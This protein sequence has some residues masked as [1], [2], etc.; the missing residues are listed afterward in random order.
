MGNRCNN[1]YCRRN[2]H[3]GVLSF[4]SGIKACRDSGRHK[5]AL[6]KA[7]K[8][9][10]YGLPAAL[11]TGIVN[12]GDYI[13][14]AITQDG[15]NYIDDETLKTIYEEADRI[16]LFNESLDFQIEAVDL[17]PYVGQRVGTLPHMNASD[18]LLAVM[19]SHGGATLAQQQAA[20]QIP[21]GIYMYISYGDGRFNFAYNYY[22]SNITQ[23]TE[24]DNYQYATSYQPLKQLR[25]YD[26]GSTEFTQWN[27]VYNIKVAKPGS[28]LLDASN[29]G[30]IDIDARPVPIGEKGR[31]NIDDW[32]F[33]WTKGVADIDDYGASHSITIPR[34]VPDVVT[35]DATEGYP[36]GLTLDDV[37]DI[38]G[39][40]TVE[41]TQEAAQEETLTEQ[42]TFRSI[43]RS[44]Q[45][46][47]G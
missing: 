26:D 40:G 22:N 12:A 9:L 16:G 6:D 42:Q 34:S 45:R 25:I 17:S 37:G 8:T 30:N 43:L 27:S 28:D 11:A 36:Y 7:Q 5:G 20:Q 24:D 13:R 38:A 31:V 2:R 46:W 4:S 19:A 35:W 41:L 39:D 10:K 14:G 29:V 18:Y 23:V 47:K 32:S 33:P 21:D 44:R 3:R 15:T 1:T